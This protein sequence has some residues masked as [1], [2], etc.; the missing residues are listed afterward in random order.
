MPNSYLLLIRPPH[1]DTQHIL[2][3]NT[4]PYSRLS[5]I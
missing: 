2:S 1:I 4:V 5:L 3:E